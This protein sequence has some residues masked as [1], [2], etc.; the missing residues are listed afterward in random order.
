M[1]PETEKR[2]E[3][4]DERL[5][6]AEKR[7][8]TTGNLVSKV[9]IPSLIEAQMK[10]DALMESDIRLYDSMQTIAEVHKR[11]AESQKELAESHKQLAES[12][13]Q[14]AESHKQ[15]DQKLAEAAQSTDAALNRLAATVQKFIESM[16]KGSN[17]SKS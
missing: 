8:L 15:L 1:D 12:H 13:K 7:I 14:L 10:I 4:F 3:G 9:G 11:L 2:F 17:G 6:L 5:R 16:N